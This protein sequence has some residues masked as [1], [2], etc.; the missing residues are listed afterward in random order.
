[1]NRLIYLKFTQN[2]YY[3]AKVL[4]LRFHNTQ[5]ITPAKLL[6]KN[7]SKIN[8]LLSKKFWGEVQCFVET[9]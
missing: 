9:N 3:S 8:I 7:L 6:C 1:M 4:K 2:Y 5:T